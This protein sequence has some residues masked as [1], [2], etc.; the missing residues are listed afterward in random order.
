MAFRL[1][2]ICSREEI[3]EI[4]LEELKNKFLIPRNYHPKIIEA[5]FQKIRNLP[6]INFFERR[7]MSL[8]KKQPKDK[9]TNRTTA[10]FD[11]NPFLPKISSVLDKHFKAMLLK[12]TDPPMAALRQPPNLRKILCRSKLYPITRA[13]KYSRKCHKNAPGWKK[14]GKGSTTC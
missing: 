9:Q 13:D 5:E 3:F 6:G 14:C 4:R 10:P 1:L 11:F 12:K 7:K 8:E 2:R